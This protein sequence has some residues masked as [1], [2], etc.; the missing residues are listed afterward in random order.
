MGG[1]WKDKESF[2][3]LVKKMIRNVSIGRGIIESSL[4]ILSFYRRS[5]LIRFL[6]ESSEFSVIEDLGISRFAT[7][8]E[9]TPVTVPICM[10][11]LSYSSN[12]QFSS[13]DS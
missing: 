10:A 13:F 5:K 1:E 8:I 2:F 4:E 9:T 11:N 3:S 12:V 7:M 6:R